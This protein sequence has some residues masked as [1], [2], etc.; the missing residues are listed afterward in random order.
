VCIR[1]R[2]ARRKEISSENILMAYFIK[3]KYDFWPL[4]PALLYVCV[5]WATVKQN[6]ILKIH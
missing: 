4:D 1:G 2:A 3:N 6:V 5:K